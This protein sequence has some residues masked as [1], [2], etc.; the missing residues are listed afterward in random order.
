MKIAG[1]LRANDGL[2]NQ[3]AKERVKGLLIQAF[4]LPN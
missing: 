2:S 3:Q 1:T 4:W